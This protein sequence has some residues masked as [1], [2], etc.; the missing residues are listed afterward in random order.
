MKT[1]PRISAIL[2]TQ[3][4]DSSITGLASFSLSSLGL[5]A[6]LA[7]ELPTNLR[8]G[9]LAEKAVSELLKTSSNYEV[10]HEN[11]QIIEE[12]D[13]IGELDFIIQEVES[14]Q[15]IHLELAYKFYLYDPQLSLKPINCW[16]GPNRNDSLIEKLDKLKEKQFPMLHHP[17]TKAALR[18][19]NTN[20]ISQA[21]CLLASLYVPYGQTTDFANSYQAAIKGYYLDNATLLRLD[22]SGKQYY[23]P[24]KKEWGMDPSEHRRWSPL[25][26]ISAQINT[27]LE[28]QRAVLC[29]QKEG[30]EYLEYFVVW[31]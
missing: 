30:A 7:V 22:N 8:L 18:P 9:H 10:L 20:E 1:T 21:L 17:A 31:W 26:D 24:D 6:K 4:L 23:V 3:V 5:P 29:W 2:H 19:L 14:A 16:I 27:S 12:R 25:E 15:V 11:L 13:T 28:E